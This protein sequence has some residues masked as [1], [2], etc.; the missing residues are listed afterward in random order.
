[1]SYKIE[2]SNA[3]SKQFR[4]LSESLQARIQIKIDELAT[5]PRPN[6]V[7]KLKDRENAY[8]IQVGAY[9]I[10]YKIV[11]DILLISVIKIGHR[12]DVYKDEI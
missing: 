11:D 1:M 4:K 6:G 2:F 12:R 5:E 8:R 10:L 3:A 7:K 9:R